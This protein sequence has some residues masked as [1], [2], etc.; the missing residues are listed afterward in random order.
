MFGTL[1]EL[2]GHRKLRAERVIPGRDHSE[3]SA[4]LIEQTQHLSAEI[5]RAR[6]QRKD[7][8]DLQATL[9]RAYAELDRI[10]GLEPEPARIEYD[11]L[12]QRFRD[13]W[14]THDT[15]ARN[16]FLRAQGVKV[17]VSP[18]PLPE[19]LVLGRPDMIFSVSAI[20]RPGLHAVLDM[21][22]LAE[23][24]NRAEDVPVT[25]RQP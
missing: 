23:L 21:G 6:L 19:D 2:A 18:N 16:G 10:A 7:H 11:E 25:I 9:D 24:L 1:L 20:E 14:G 22:N 17:V 12:D 4:R 5:G 8:S 3:E 15:D 13:W